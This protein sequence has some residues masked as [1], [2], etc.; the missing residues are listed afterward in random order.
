VVWAHSTPERHHR[1]L[2][3]RKEYVERRKAAPGGHTQ[4]EWEAR[5]ASY[6]GLCA[7]C[8]AGHKALVK[9]HVVPV[10]AGGTNHIWN[11]VPACQSCNARKLDRTDFPP[12]APPAFDVPVPLELRWRDAPDAP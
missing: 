4:A 8:G 12:P 6:R 5:V 2:K 11:L 3:M 7:Y 1:A 9:E 10:S